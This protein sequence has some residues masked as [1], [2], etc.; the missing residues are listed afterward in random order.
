MLTAVRRPDRKVGTAWGWECRCDCGR[1]RD[2]ATSQLRQGKVRACRE[3]AP[4]LRAKTLANIRGRG[5]HAEDGLR[6]GSYTV[7]GPAR[8]PNGEVGR[9]CRCRC[10]AENVVRLYSLLTGRISGCRKCHGRFRW[11]KHWRTLRK[12]ETGRVY[13]R[14]VV[15]TVVKQTPRRGVARAVAACSCACGTPWHLV[16]LDTLHQGSVHGC[17]CITS[18]LAAYRS[19]TYSARYNP[20]IGD[21]VRASRRYAEKGFKDARA[22][23]YARDRGTCQACGVCRGRREA[24]HIRPWSVSPFHRLVK[25]AS[26]ILC[27]ACHKEF[28]GEAGYYGNT[29]PLFIPWLRRKR[30]ETGFKNAR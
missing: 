15:R 2:V 1:S 4:G 20:D 30:Q 17:G 28:H 19:G 7:L 8:F 27:Q 5:A 26:V 9:L 12:T 21:D 10:G 16:P 18:E 23:V 11:A 29:A 25:W 13:G 24:H 22:L 6:F 3:C 14:L